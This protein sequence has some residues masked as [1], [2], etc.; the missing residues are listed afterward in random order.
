VNE[1]NSSNATRKAKNYTTVLQNVTREKTVE[2][3]EEKLERKLHTISLKIER[4]NDGITALSD[5]DFK[6]VQERHKKFLI[7]EKE[8]ADKA[9]AKN[10]VEAFIFSTREKLNQDG[11]D[12]VSTE[13][14]RSKITTSLEDAENWLWEDGDDVEV[15]VYKEKKGELL[16]LVKDVL[17]RH[18]EIE[19]RK[20]AMDHFNAVIK[21]ARTR[22][23]DWVAR[24]AKR[25]A[26]NEST[27]IHKNATDRVV[28]MC[29][30]AEVWLKD[31]E[32]ELAK[33][34][35]LVKPPYTSSETLQYIRTLESGVAYLRYKPK[36]YSKKKPKAS[37]KT[38]TSNSTSN[39]TTV[40]ST[41]AEKDPKAEKPKDEAKEGKQD[42]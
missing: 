23:V 4:K 18:E 34:G 19:K 41:A 6:A 12:T 37:N 29:D 15:K 32:A 40:N 3:S 26:A 22:V 27:W 9:N 35:L 39:K 11:I 16:T 38:N 30:E 33:A 5:E 24:E 10:E 42:L 7:E 28:K 14:E 31:N 17:Y 13:D 25:I 1:S 20:S 2:V 8:K 21:D 36:P